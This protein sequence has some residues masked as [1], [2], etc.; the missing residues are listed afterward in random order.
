MNKTLLTLLLL[1]LALSLGAQAGLFDISYGMSRE[2][3]IE[4]MDIQDF[5]V[6][7]E[8][9]NWLVLIPSDNYYVDS[10]EIRFAEDGS[11]ISGWTIVYLPQDDEDIEDLVLEAL[12][13]RHGD[14]YEWD[15]YLLEYCWDLDD[16]GHSVFA[17][18]DWD[19]E[20]YCAE[21]TCW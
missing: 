15:Y 4:L 12:I 21:Y 3:T 19:G 6:A 7:D 13:E 17:G 5:S 2:E 20:T 18:W 9:D 10:I 16:E 1:A 8:G 11:G 14:D